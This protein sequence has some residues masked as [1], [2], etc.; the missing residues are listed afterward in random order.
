MQFVF[1]WVMVNVSSCATVTLTTASQESA[2]CR[3]HRLIR[4]WFTSKALDECG[5][6]LDRKGN[7]PLPLTLLTWEKDLLL[8]RKGNFHELHCTTCRETFLRR[9]IYK[10]CAEGN[11][12]AQTSS[13]ERES[14]VSLVHFTVNHIWWWSELNVQCYP[15]LNYMPFKYLLLPVPLCRIKIWGFLKQELHVIYFF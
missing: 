13:G 12:P 7:L 10:S 14:Y 6:M 8:Y 15:N 5:W 1:V 2:P 3:S 11:E 9:H 4:E